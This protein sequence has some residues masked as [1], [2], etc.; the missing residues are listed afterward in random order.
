[1]SRE[2]NQ[3]YLRG[4]WVRSL[5]LVPLVIVSVGWSFWGERSRAAALTGLPWLAGLATVAIMGAF[6][7][8]WSRRLINGMTN[9]LRSATPEP[10]L[11]LV[12]ASTKRATLVADMDAF[13][14]QSCAVALALYGE[15]QRAR[16]RLKPIDW[17]RRAPLVRAAGV[18]SE[19]LIAL[20]CDGD[21]EVG[22]REAKR[23]K[24]LAELAPGTVG[25][26]ASDRFYASVLALAQILAGEEDASAV[27]T[28][29][30]AAQ[31]SMYPTLKAIALAGLAADALQSGPPENAD[32]RR[33]ELASFAPTLDKL[34]FG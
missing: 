23:A 8:W 17:H 26:K 12:E 27:P 30:S 32:A 19:S 5:W 29:Q 4:L 16:E 21:F 2:K 33:K 34:L 10:L 14:A 31:V 15:G 24:S 9:A 3:K 18:V 13:G 7:W 11:A 28:L 20:L 25:A 1:M 6:M 22:L